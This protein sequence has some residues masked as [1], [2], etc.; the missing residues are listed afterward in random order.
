MN[1][2]D[3]AVC[4]LIATAALGACN[5]GPAAEEAQATDDR[6]AERK[7]LRASAEQERLALTRRDQGCSGHILRDEELRSAVAGNQMASKFS[8]KQVVYD[9]PSPFRAYLANGEFGTTDQF[10]HGVIGR[11]W[12]DG[13]KLCSE[14]PYGGGCSRL[15]RGS[16]GEIYEEFLNFRYPEATGLVCAAMHIE[17]LSSH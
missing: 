4:I 16:D 9:A 17:R 12:I 8:L 14:N 7:A 15:I 3:I 10:R 2:K 11:Y 6:D 1:L 13:D 5:R